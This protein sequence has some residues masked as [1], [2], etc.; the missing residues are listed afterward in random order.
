MFGDQV[1][2][3]QSPVKMLHIGGIARRLHIG[4]KARRLQQ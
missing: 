4:G 1:S 2:L 3:L